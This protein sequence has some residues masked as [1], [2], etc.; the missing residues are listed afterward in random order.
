MV[1]L[2]RHGPGGLGG[3]ARPPKTKTAT[4]SSLT[5][6]KTKGG[7]GVNARP[8]LGVNARPP[9]ANATRTSSLSRAKATSGGLGA[10]AGPKA[11][12]AFALAQ[13][14]KPLPCKH[15]LAAA[16]AAAAVQATQA[17]A[18][19]MAMTT[20]TPTGIE[21]YTI[22]FT[23]LCIFFGFML[24]RATASARQR[25][26]A[27]R[28]QRD[29]PPDSIEEYSDDGVTINDYHEMIDPPVPP[30]P[31]GLAPSPSPTSPTPEPSLPYKAGSSGTGD[32]REQPG[33]ALT[34]SS[35]TG[36]KRNQPGKALTVSRYFSAVK[37]SKLRLEAHGRDRSG[38]VNEVIDLAFVPP[39]PTT[40]EEETDDVTEADFVA[41]GFID[42]IDDHTTE[43]GRI[44]VGIAADIARVFVH[45]QGMLHCHMPLTTAGSNQHQLRFTC[46]I[47]GKIVARWSIAR[48]EFVHHL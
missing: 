43:C 20:P 24:G 25:G 14:W 19:Y 3:T 26:R 42:A 23:V 46:Q 10:N 17:E 11:W 44:A 15:A 9:Q 45:E 18:H 12:V 7:L 21:N 37:R 6:A 2:S 1:G 47:C 34:V 33:K 32:L 5:V 39:A 13:A 4:T 29:P 40:S 30:A 22:I 35:E 28:P 27:A 36:D 31:M 16:A 48:R 8:R 38:M 41:R